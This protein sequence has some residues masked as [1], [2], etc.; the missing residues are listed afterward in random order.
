MKEKREFRDY[1]SDI[2]DAI[3][4]IED[5]TQNSYYDYSSYQGFFAII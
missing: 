3:K 5:F 4:K 2:L 1:L